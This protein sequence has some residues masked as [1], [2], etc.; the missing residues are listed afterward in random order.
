MKKRK[1]VWLC[2]CFLLALWGCQ[3]EEEKESQEEFYVYEIYL[4]EKGEEA[5]SI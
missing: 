4:D 5:V 2:A 1:K 3:R